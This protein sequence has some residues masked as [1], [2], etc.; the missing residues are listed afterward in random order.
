MCADVLCFQPASQKSKLKHI[1]SHI[2]SPFVVS[3]RWNFSSRAQHPNRVEKLFY[4]FGRTAEKQ[5][6]KQRPDVKRPK[7]TRKAHRNQLY[8][9]SLPSICSLGLNIFFRRKKT[10]PSYHRLELMDEP[11]PRALLH[12]AF[13]G[14]YQFDKISSPSP[15]G[16]NIFSTKVRVINHDRHS[17]SPSNARSYRPLLRRQSPL[18][19]TRA[20]WFEL[21]TPYRELSL[22]L[23]ENSHDS[24]LTAHLPPS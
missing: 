4:R 17:F 7:Q 22:S 16:G 24:H 14:S 12:F 5:K 18:H 13:F 19:S 20:V 8:I 2:R 1:L 10:K 3:Q 15:R 6:P 11:F 9:L 21:N 23:T